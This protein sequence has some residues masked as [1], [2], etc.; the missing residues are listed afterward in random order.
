[1]MTCAACHAQVSEAALA[2]PACGAPTKAPAGP[3]DF[4]FPPPGTPSWHWWV[5]GAAVLVAWAVLKAA[6]K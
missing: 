6:V 3:A 4:V 2:C 5:V 1:M